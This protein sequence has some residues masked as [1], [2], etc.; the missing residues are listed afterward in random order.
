M[1]G[2]RKSNPKSGT[3]LRGIA[4]ASAVIYTAFVAIVAFGGSDASYQASLWGSW[5]AVTLV[6]IVTF[7]IGETMHRSATTSD[8]TSTDHS[9]VLTSV[10]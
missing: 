2:T 5:V 1:A 4:I 9:P 7:G 8:G 6:A 10:G 3:T